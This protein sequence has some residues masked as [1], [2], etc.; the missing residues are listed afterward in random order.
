MRLLQPKIRYILTY[1]ISGT[2]PEVHWLHQF[3]PHYTPHTGTTQWSHEWGYTTYH[4]RKLVRLWMMWVQPDTSI[5]FCFPASLRGQAR[6][7]IDPFNCYERQFPAIY[8]ILSAAALKSHMSVAEQ[9]AGLTWEAIYELED[10]FPAITATKYLSGEFWH[11]RWKQST[12]SPSRCCS[13]WTRNSTLRPLI[14]IWRWG[15]LLAIY[16]KRLW[17]RSFVI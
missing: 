3:S 14:I 12:Q 11:S 15:R 16:L 17:Y 13:R 6:W 7:G 4:Y 10:S 5:W 8:I 1:Y 2:N 9:P